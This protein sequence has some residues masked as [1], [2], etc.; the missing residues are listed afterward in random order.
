MTQGNVRGLALRADSL[1][2]TN[3]TPVHLQTFAKL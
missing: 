2:D 1:P 3:A